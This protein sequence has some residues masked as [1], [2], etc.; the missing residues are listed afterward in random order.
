[1]AYQQTTGYVNCACGPLINFHV[2]G[3][4]VPWHRISKCGI[5]WRC[6]QWTINQLTMTQRLM[7][8]T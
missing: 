2:T 8:I 1:M 7:K 3:I 6:I 4:Q 5:A